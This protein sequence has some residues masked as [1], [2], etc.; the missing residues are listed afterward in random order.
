MAKKIVKKV[1][2]L[3]PEFVNAK[4]VEAALDDPAKLS[5]IFCFFIQRSWAT[6]CFDQTLAFFAQMAAGVQAQKDADQQ[7]YLRQLMTLV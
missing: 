5:K 1:E 4:L 7:A 6:M 3:T 2:I